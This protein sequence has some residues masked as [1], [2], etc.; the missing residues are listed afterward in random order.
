MCHSLG[1][2]EGAQPEQSAL[3]D[4]GA[5]LPS[6]I[7]VRLAC[8]L[9]WLQHA[10]FYVAPD[11]FL[12][13][14]MPRQRCRPWSS[15]YFCLAGIVV[16]YR[17]DVTSTALVKVPNGCERTRQ[18]WRERSSVCEHMRAISGE[19][20]EVLC[21]KTSQEHFVLYYQADETLIT[22]GRTLD[23]IFQI[24]DVAHVYCNV[25]GSYYQKS[26]HT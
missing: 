16:T 18:L 4:I 22:S 10:E 12:Q 14:C 20:Y 9:A 17:P 26:I 6:F 25:G 2:G 7:G 23:E 19:L 21:N 24:D 1:E 11:A 13:H 8:R 5:Y 15:N 3:L